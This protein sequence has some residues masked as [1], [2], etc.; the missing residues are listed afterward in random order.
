MEVKIFDLG[1]IDYLKAW[2]FQKKI[3]QEVKEG[4]IPHGLILCA[5]PPVITIGRTGSRKNILVS[6]EALKLK[7]I[8]VY[9]IERGGDVTYHGPG[10]LMIYPVFNLGSLKE[11]LRWFL[12]SLEELMIRTLVDFGIKAKRSPGL[13]GAWIGDKKIASIGITVKNWIT[14]HGACLNVNNSCLTNFSL[15][16]PCG[17]DIMMSSIE[18]AL[19]RK[20]ETEEVKKA[21]KRRISK[22]LK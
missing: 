1:T 8:A 20:I 3:F 4:L 9:E 5:H 6:E 13:T 16:R 7:G 2:E 12:N 11:D 22:W 21:L 19:G 10:Q 17:M 14:Y 15:I 18:S